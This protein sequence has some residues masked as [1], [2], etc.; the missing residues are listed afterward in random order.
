MFGI[1]KPSKGGVSCKFVLFAGEQF[2]AKTAVEYTLF[3]M[4]VLCNDRVAVGNYVARRPN[5]KFTLGA[6][7]YFTNFVPA[8]EAVFA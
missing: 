1:D 6:G 8:D 4:A 5:L 3:S 7:G 2:E